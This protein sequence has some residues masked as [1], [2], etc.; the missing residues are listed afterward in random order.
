VDERMR[1]DARAALQRLRTDLAA[2][3]AA[4]EMPA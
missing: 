2:G 1:T 4:A 3:V